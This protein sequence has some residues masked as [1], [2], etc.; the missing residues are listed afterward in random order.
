MLNLRRQ[1][2]KRQ[3][4]NDPLYR[5]QSLEEVA[6]AAQLGVKIEVNS[7]T[8]FTVRTSNGFDREKWLW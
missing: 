5:F 1:S 2:L 6:I 8:N 7:I 3:I 4:L